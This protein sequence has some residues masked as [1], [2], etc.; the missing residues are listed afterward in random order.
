MTITRLLASLF[1]ELR[2]AL[3]RIMVVNTVEE[4]PIRVK[5]LPPEARDLSPDSV[6]RDTGVAFLLVNHF[7]QVDEQG[8]ERDAWCYAA[9]AQMVFDFYKKKVRQCD[10]AGLVK[11]PILGCCPP[12]LKVCTDDGCDHPD[13]A[14]IYSHWGISSVPHLQPNGR[15]SWGD[16][17]SEIRA[18]R[19]VEVVRESVHV[20]GNFHAIIV[21]GFN[22]SLGL[23][24]YQDPQSETTNDVM[25][26]SELISSND[27]RWDSTWTGLK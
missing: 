18:G 21:I 25:S 14:R 5:S 26:F 12:A 6:P 22:D 27:F 9:C 13:I 3:R 7:R 19:P 10:I 17:K 20:P 4:I 24:M 11:N 2:R 1:S 8:I 16:L 23:V 15:I